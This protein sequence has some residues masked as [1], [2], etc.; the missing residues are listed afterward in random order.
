MERL[1]KISFYIIISGVLSFFLIFEMDTIE[2]MSIIPIGITVLG[3]ILFLYSDF[4]INNRITRK[5]IAFLIF[6]I[7]FLLFYTTVFM[8]GEYMDNN[9]SETINMLTTFG[10]IIPLILSLFYLIKHSKITRKLLGNLF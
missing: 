3:T 5:S 8:F 2:T 10:L 7:S 4:K 6:I 9:F 1:K